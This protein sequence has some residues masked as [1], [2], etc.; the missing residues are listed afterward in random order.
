MKIEKNVE[1]DGYSNISLTTAAYG[2]GGDLS[3]A[4]VAVL[5][6]LFKEASYKPKQ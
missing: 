6:S 2:V 5:A 4:K 1:Y 3:Y